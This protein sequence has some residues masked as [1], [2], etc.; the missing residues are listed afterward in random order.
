MPHAHFRVFGAAAAA[1]DSHVREFAQLE[2]QAKSAAVTS[3]ASSASSGALA[4]LFAFYT[5]LLTPAAFTSPDFLA[6]L[7]TKL[8]EH[9]SARY[10]RD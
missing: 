10:S 8:A 9:F 5:R 4:E 1:A 6:T 3:G 7:F 2:A